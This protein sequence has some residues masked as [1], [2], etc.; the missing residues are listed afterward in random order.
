MDYNTAWPVYSAI[1]DRMRKVFNLFPEDEGVLV[2]DLML[3][4]INDEKKAEDPATFENE[5]A[6][7]LPADREDV[8]GRTLPRINLREE[9]EVEGEGE[10]GEDG[11]S[12]DY[13]DSVIDTL[14]CNDM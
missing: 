2:T 12:E 3:Q 6:F 13:E 14:E 5:N 9:S 10:Y 7:I 8:D 1:L 11:G 4:A